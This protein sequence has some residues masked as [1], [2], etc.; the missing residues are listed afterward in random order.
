MAK[1]MIQQSR[2]TSPAEKAAY[3]QIAGAG[4]SRVKREFFGLSPEDEDAIVKRIEEGLDAE[5]RKAGW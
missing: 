1:T 3:H 4:K 2:R 5:F